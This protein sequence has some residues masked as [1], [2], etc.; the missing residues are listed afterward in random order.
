MSTPNDTQIAL[1]HEVSQ[2]LF[3]EAE[4]LDDRR[5][6]DWLAQ[7]VDEGIRYIVPL[8][9]TMLKEDGDGFRDDTQ[10]QDDDWKAVTMRVQRFDSRAA[11]SENPPTRLRHHVGS[12]RVQGPEQDDRIAVKSNILLYR[13]RG[14][15]AHHDLLSAERHDVLVRQAD[16]LRLQRREVYLDASTVGTHNFSFFF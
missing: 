3:H 13:S 2:F 12:I 1:Y 6:K 5:L 9:Q 11:W 7:C 10:L 16:G 8:R 14:E 15:S 4:L